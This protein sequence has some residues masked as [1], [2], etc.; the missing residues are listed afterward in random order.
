M[1]SRIKKDFWLLNRAVAHRGLHGEGVGENTLTAYSLAIQNG[2]PIEMDVQL[3]K[4]GV[5]VCFHDD[6]L[7]RVTGE[8]SLIWDKTYEEIKHLKIS[9]TGD[10]IPTFEQFLS[11]VDG[12][13]P[14]LIEIKQQRTAKEGI[15]QK[16]IDALKGYKGEYVI[17]SFDPFVMMRVRKINPSIIRG[18][19][20]G[21]ASKSNLPFIKRLVVNKLLLNFLSKPDFIN[22]EL[23]GAPLKSKLPTVY[24]T[25]RTEE[26]KN[27]LEKLGAN[28]VFENVTPSNNG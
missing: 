10:G 19:L 2:Y 26:Q 9:G 15:E 18:Q 17:Q 24:W 4:D 11:F 16:V 3:T 1:K 28:F 23:G 7:L 5:P 12:K 21:G 6:S 20:G 25:V 13:V 27:R 22:Y 8:N 14:L